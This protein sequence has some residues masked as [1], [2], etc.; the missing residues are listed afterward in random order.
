LKLQDKKR[1]P[2]NRLPEKNEVYSNE[3]L[4]SAESITNCKTEA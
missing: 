2:Y 1:I 4:E 3:N